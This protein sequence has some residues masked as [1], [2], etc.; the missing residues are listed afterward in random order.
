[1][2]ERNQRPLTA[3]LLEKT[4]VFFEV[5]T[6][7]LA[8]DEDSHLL[9]GLMEIFGD[10]AF[11]ESGVTRDDLQEIVNVAPAAG[12]ALVDLYRVF[13]ATRDDVEALRERMTDDNFLSTSAYELR[14][15]LTPIR[16]FAEILHDHENIDRSDQQRFAGILVRESERLAEIIDRM[17]SLSSGTSQAADNGARLPAEQVTDFLQDH[18]NYFAALEEV[19]AEMRWA[20]GLVDSSDVGALLERLS[21]QYRMGLEVT[22]GTPDDTRLA[23][24]DA[25]ERQLV[26]SERL[27]PASRLFQLAKTIASVHFAEAIEDCIAEDAIVGDA[28]RTLCRDVLAKYVAG[29]VL[30]PYECFLDAAQQ[31]RYDID[32]LCSRF[33][34]SFEQVCHRLATLQRPGAAGIPVHFVRS[35]I[36]GNI[37]KRFSL[38]GFRI[39]RFGGICPR[40]NLHAAFMTPGR[41]CSQIGRMPDGSAFFTIARTISKPAPGIGLGDSH[42]AV[43]IG[44]AVGDASGLRYSDGID[45][46]AEASMTPVG[47]TC[48]LCDRLDC[49]QRAH[50]P[51]LGQS[52]AT[53][54]PDIHETV[55]T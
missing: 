45:L 31:S 51:I 40:S 8:Q 33:Q 14:S 52:S 47:V 46:A 55:S 4:A 44:C 37:S 7:A 35:D 15:V 5:G 43:A 13:R 27:A 22:P 34:A 42:L 53:A 50:P 36:A 29:A 38:S 16:S 23:H 12:R 41:I 11:A 21:R 26:L 20:A 1:M 9:V 25:T 18:L 10:S 30:L 28:A 48:R 49:G 24:F 32:L 19:A 39:A 17:L 3:R 2:I 6:A 54:R